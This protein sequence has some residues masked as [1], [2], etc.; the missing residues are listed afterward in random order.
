VAKQYLLDILSKVAPSG[1]YIMEQTRLHCTYK[2]VTIEMLKDKE[3]QKVITKEFPYEAWV[4]PFSEFNAV[5][6]RD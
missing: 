2:D 6:E 3:F 4:K 1:Q 5:S